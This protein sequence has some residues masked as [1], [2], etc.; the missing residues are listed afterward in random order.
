M[1]LGSISTGVPQLDA[2]YRRQAQERAG[3]V[4]M[5]LQGNAMGQA[6]SAK[7]LLKDIRSSGTQLFFVIDSAYLTEKIINSSAVQKRMQD[8]IEVSY[9]YIQNNAPEDTG[10]YK[11]SFTKGFINSNNGMVGII[12]TEDP[13]W[14]HLEFGTRY[15]S[16]RP[17]IRKA[18]ESNP[19]IQP[20]PQLKGLADDIVL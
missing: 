14:I 4:A 18:L 8:A 16:P 11:K 9:Q 20:A 6:S 15:M 19:M 5:A 3:K 17:V 12:R 2:V 7:V 1:R 10:F 13:K